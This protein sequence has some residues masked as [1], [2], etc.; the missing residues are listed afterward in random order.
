MNEAARLFCAAAPHESLNFG[1]GVMSLAQ[2]G[3]APRCLRGLARA[4]I[5][6]KG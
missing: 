4:E 2:E 6:T 3:I 5:G 1:L